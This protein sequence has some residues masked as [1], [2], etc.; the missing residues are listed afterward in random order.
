MSCH[1]L[2]CF[3]ILQ[4]EDTFGD[5]DESEEDDVVVTA[6]STGGVGEATGGAAAARPRLGLGSSLASIV[7][8]QGGNTPT[9][10]LQDHPI[11]VPNP[12][13]NPNDGVVLLL[14]LPSTK[15]RAPT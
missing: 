3:C 10:S 5:S 1:V 2:S 4:G 14:E 13:T 6:S 12:N 8:G 9:C 11:Q 15:I 7:H